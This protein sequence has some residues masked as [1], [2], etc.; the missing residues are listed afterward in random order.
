VARKLGDNEL[1]KKRPPQITLTIFL[2]KVDATD[3]DTFFSDRG[4]L[5]HH[6]LKDGKT[7]IGD[8]YIKRPRPKPPG[9]GK[10]FR[11]YV[12]PKELGK[13]SSTAGVLV[14]PV[15]NR[16]FAITFGQGRFLLESESWEESFGLLVTLNSVP[17]NRIKSID[18]R[19]FDALS[20]HS[21]VQSSQEATPQDFGLDVE[22]DLVR[23]V[24]GSP[25]DSELGHRLSGMDALRTCVSVALE[26]LPNL[27]KRYQTQFHSKAYRQNFPWVD[28]ISEVTRASQKEE[29]DNQVV[30]QIR[31]SNL[32]RCWMAVPEIVDWASIDGFRYGLSNKHPKHHD[33]H[34]KDFLEEVPD[35]A[36]ITIEK[37]RQ[38]QV[39]GTGDD[40][41]QLYQ[42][43]VYRCI[44]CELD[45][46]NESY[47]LSG[48]KW[49]RVTRDFVAEVNDSFARITRYENALP[50][51]DDNSEGEYNERVA[52]GG[53]RPFALMDKKIISFGGGKF[54]FCDLY[55]REKDIIHVKRYGGS[56]IFSHLFAQGTASGELFQTQPAFRDL[57][58][59]RLPP[60]HKLT[61]CAKRPDSREYQ[62]VFAVV[63]D[64]D[65]PDL[66]I[67]FFSRLN[68][69]SAVRRLDGYGYRVAIT[70]ISV[71]Q[72]RS[73]LKRY[74]IA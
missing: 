65:E 74:G 5:D 49:Y 56:S 40:D 59:Q 42:W 6:S 48:G 33:I 60:T 68:L 9:W 29:L 36:T 26:Q 45:L 25:D 66:T 32:E 21:K 37:L 12:D 4:S 1:W 50:E 44:Y 18:K 10:F 47:L 27:V 28:H 73:K 11:D 58:N 34:L 23:A 14:I 13:A 71:S 43:S 52:N 24:V 64:S 46:R 61:D 67:P 38:R 7:A 2:I 57:V 35:P 72:N 30:D 54:E 3:I 62:I 63:S 17:Q 20:T 15:E 53:T 55:T 22:Q 31:G 51:Y 70:K 8:L 16:W 19:T 41:R 39:Y 69:R